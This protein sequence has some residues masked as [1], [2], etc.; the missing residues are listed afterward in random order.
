VEL[1]ARPAGQVDDHPR[2]GLVQIGGGLVQVRMTDEPDNE[3]L[4]RR[5]EE[6]TRRL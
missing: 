1:Q 5:L 6:V 2:Q 3:A 4:Q